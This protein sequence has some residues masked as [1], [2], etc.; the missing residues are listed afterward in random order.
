MKDDQIL[1]IDG[2]AGRQRGR[3]SGVAFQDQAGDRDQPQLARDDKEMDLKATLGER[4]G[5]KGGKS[6][7][8]MQNSMGSKLSDRRAGFPIILQ[9]DSV[10]KPTDCGGPLVNLDGKVLGNQHRPRGPHRELR[11]PSEAVRRCWRN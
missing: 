9:H 11:D 8:E 7:G 4:P 6:R 3:F 2:K 5:T 10:L 1:A